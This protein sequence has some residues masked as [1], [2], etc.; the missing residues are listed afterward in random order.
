MHALR[1]IC[2]VV[3]R[4]GAEWERIAAEPASVTQL[5]VR[6][7]LPL[8]LLAPAAAVV[9]M[10]FF[11]IDWDPRHGYRVEAANILAAG[12]TTYVALVGSILALAAIFV[13]IAPLYGS[14]R[15]YV[16]ALKVATFGSVPVLLAGG[17]LVIPVMAVVAMLAGLQTLVLLW[18]GAGHVLQVRED[19]RSEFVGASMILLVAASTIA[20]AAASGLGFL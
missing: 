8:A 9:G 7:V 19:S 6:Y 10:R 1:R 16:A 20:G 18:E 15:S 13:A 3:V 12:A 5:L 17:T 4:P 14:S 11:G 2:N